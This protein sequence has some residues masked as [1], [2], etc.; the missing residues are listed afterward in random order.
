MRE[1]GTKNLFEE[2]MAKTFPNMRKATDN[3]IQEAQR[4]PNK[5][6]KTPISKTHYN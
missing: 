1:K 2:I 4:L 5:N 3:H 6:P